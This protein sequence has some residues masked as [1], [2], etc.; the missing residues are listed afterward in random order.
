MHRRQ[1]LMVTGSARDAVV[2]LADHHD[3]AELATILGLGFDRSAIP[4]LVV[5]QAAIT[6]AANPAAGRLFGTESSALVGHRNAD[7][8]AA[9]WPADDDRRAV[10]VRLGDR[11]HLER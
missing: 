4:M 9:E 10:A 6:V 11:E 3:S 5:D 2:R 1:G 8:S 7:F